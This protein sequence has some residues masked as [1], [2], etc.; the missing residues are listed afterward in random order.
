MSAL[1]SISVFSSSPLAF[2]G[3]VG[4][5]NSTYAI[6]VLHQLTLQYSLSLSLLMDKKRIVNMSL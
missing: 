4:S 1:N 2:L 5:L 3:S 6:L